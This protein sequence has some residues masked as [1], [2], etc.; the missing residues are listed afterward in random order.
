MNR[1]RLLG[2]IGCILALAPAACATSQ[3]DRHFEAGQYT[4]AS[5]LFAEDS[6]LQRREQALFRTALVYA[7]P[8]SPVYQPTLA[9]DLFERLLTLYPKTSYRSDV[10]FL[11]GLL[12]EVERLETTAADRSVELERLTRRLDEVEERARWLETLLERQELQS[13]IFRELAERLELE[14]RETRAQLGTLQDE[15]E[16]L[17]EIDLKARPRPGGSTPGT[18]RN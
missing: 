9:R 16:R 15:L 12:D 11:T 1:P 8:A 18:S 3:F 4:E 10:A 13:S 5:R 17:K 14:L 2:T 6:A 7:L